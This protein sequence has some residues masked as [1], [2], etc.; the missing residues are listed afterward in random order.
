LKFGTLEVTLPTGN[1]TDIATPPANSQ[2]NFRITYGS[3]TYKMLA[4]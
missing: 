1:L 3:T 2:K 4:V